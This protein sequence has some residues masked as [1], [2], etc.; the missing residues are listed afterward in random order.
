[1]LV[2]H[3]GLLFLVEKKKKKQH[4]FR[5]ARVRPNNDFFPLLGMS[6]ILT[7]PEI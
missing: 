2:E 7:F 6:L 5:S 4:R 1:M 3:T